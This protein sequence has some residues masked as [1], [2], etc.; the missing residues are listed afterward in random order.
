[1]VLIAVLSM[2]GAAAGSFLAGL[3][4]DSSRSLGLVPLGATA[5]ALCLSAI[6]LIPLTPI[7]LCVLVGVG[8]GLVNVPLLAAY[9][10]SFPPDTRG[11]CMAV[12]NTSGFVSM[13]AMSLVVAGL[14]HEGILTALGQLAF[15]TALSALGAAAAWWFLGRSTAALFVQSSPEHDLKGAGA[16][17][18]I[19][20]ASCDVEE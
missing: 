17:G 11:N 18:P 16:E 1:L 2:A 12:L 10:A 14:A 19:S 5:L 20:T 6:A 8:G 9:Q 7:W 15:V 13:T 3:A 4:G